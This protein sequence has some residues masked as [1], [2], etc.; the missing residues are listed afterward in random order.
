MPFSKP[1]ISLFSSD[2]ES[3]EL[4]DSGGGRRLERIGRFLIDRPEPKAWWRPVEPQ[5]RWAEADL[6]FDGDRGWVGKAVKDGIWELNYGPARF[7]ARLSNNK[8]LGVFPEQAALWGWISQQV[9]A[10]SS[11]SP[12]VLNL[13]GYTGV[14]SL[15]AAHAG[16]EVTHVD[17]S[18]PAITQGRENIERLD[19]SHLSIRW[20]VDDVRAFVARELRRG[21]RYEGIILDPPSFGRGPRQEVW[22]SSEQLADLL[23]SCAQLLS[24]DGQ[25]MVATV[26]SIEASATMVSNLFVDALGEREGV[27]EAGE[28]AV[29]PRS[30]YRPL[31]LSLVGRWSKSG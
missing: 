27:I 17:G 29:M 3:Y 21:N 31:S 4:V 1:D 8:H 23:S 5:S 22:K 10:S 9:S 15:V 24:D 16:A 26:Y 12:R 18:K 30:G 20:I 11:R 28:I 6:V 13:F 19:Q 25:F 7:F 14:A 2:W